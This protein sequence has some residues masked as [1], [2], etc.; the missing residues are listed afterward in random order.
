MMPQHPAA[1]VMHWRP[2]SWWRHARAH[3]HHFA[4]VH[5]RRFSPCARWENAALAFWMWFKEN[6]P[7]WQWWQF[8]MN[9]VA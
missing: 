8:A 9:Q 1:V 7:T 6:E 2:I 4:L 3:H 5:P